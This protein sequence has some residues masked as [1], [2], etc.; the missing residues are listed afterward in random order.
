MVE[1]ATRT[2]FLK[3]DLQYEFSLLFGNLHL[4]SER[5]ASNSNCLPL[6]NKKAFSL[7][8]KVM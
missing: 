1:S 5:K 4:R 7:A 3:V 6:L 2:L 8:F